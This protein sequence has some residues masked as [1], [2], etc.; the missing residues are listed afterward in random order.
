MHSGAE[1]EATGQRK[2]E[3][4]PFSSIFAVSIHCCSLLLQSVLVLLAEWYLLMQTAAC[5]T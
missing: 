4:L 5:V 3:P 1:A 2:L